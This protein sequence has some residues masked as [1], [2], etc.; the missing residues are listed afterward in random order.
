VTQQNSGL[1]TP[2]E[3]CVGS[4]F[5][6]LAR[7]HARSDAQIPR[8]CARVCVYPTQVTPDDPLRVTS[9]LAG[10]WWDSDL[11][12]VSQEPTPEPCLHDDSCSIVRVP[13]GGGKPN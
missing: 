3:T 12:I 11:S 7:L 4:C 13:T 10:T 6:V 1:C 5:A 2:N 9:A 8:A